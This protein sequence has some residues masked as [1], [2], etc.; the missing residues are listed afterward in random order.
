MKTYN[1]YQRQ[2]REYNKLQGFNR[3]KELYV[4]YMKEIDSNNYHIYNK[5]FNKQTSLIKTK[6]GL[7]HAHNNKFERMWSQEIGKI[8][9]I[10]KIVINKNVN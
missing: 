6:H 3:I 1:K 7:V 10:K 8:K 4:S 5:M 9:K 2:L